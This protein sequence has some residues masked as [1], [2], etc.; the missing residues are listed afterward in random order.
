MLSGYILKGDTQINIKLSQYKPLVI[1]NQL[2]DDFPQLEKV[3]FFTSQDGE[4]VPQDYY[5]V[6][7]YIREYS[8]G[9][10]FGKKISITDGINNRSNRREISHDLFGTL[11]YALSD[12]NGSYYTSDLD[13]ITIGTKQ[14]YSNE[15]ADLNL[16]MGYIMNHEIHIID[17]INKSI[18]DNLKPFSQND[19][20]QK[21]ITHG[22][23]NRYDKSKLSDIALP[24]SI[25]GMS[26]TQSVP[27]VVYEY[28]EL[29]QI[30]RYL[31]N[32]YHNLD[33]PSRWSLR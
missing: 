16:G 9:S 19:I 25:Y 28:D 10:F 13:I 33:I 7:K 4:I 29:F 8:H 32:N 23:F 31:K 2:M 15:I 3:C 20:Q 12:E 22:P 14:K 5:R 24:V 17:S 18:H 26:K 11:I 27:F 6:S 21:I 1:K 30:F